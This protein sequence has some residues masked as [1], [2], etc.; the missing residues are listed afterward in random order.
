[1]IVQIARIIDAQTDEE[2][3]VPKKFAPLLI[4]ERTVGLPIVLNSLIGLLVLRLQLANSLKE[5][6]CQQGWFAAR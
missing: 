3:V 2:I 4:Q 1:V 5:G 6:K